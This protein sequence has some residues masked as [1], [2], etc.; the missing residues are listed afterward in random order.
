MASDIENL[1]EKTKN[2]SIDSVY[3]TNWC[4]M[5]DDIK[6]ECIGKMELS[7]RSSLRC[8]AKAE[9]SLVDSQKIKFTEG[10]LWGCYDFI[11]SLENE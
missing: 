2:L 8:T 10:L 5:P 6:L 3:D 7:E 4:H 1:T 9:R 11:G